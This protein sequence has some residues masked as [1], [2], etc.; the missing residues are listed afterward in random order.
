MPPPTAPLLP[1]IAAVS[2]RCKLLDVAASGENAPPSFEAV[3]CDVLTARRDSARKEAESAKAGLLR[4]ASSSILA[5]LEATD[6]SGEG[7]AGMLRSSDRRMWEA[8]RSAAAAKIA[9]VDRV[10]LTC[11]KQLR[12]SPLNFAKHVE[13]TLDVELPALQVAAARDLAT[14]TRYELVGREYRS[15]QAVL[16]K[17]FAL[18]AVKVLCSSVVIQDK[19]W[20]EAGVPII[21]ASAERPEWAATLS[22]ASS[23]VFSALVGWRG[24]A[25]NLVSASA[26]NDL[27]KMVGMEA[28]G[29]ARLKVTRRFCPLIAPVVRIRMASLESCLTLSSPAFYAPPLR[30]PVR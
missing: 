27:G 11:R 24:A 17:S 7:R 15:I 16:Q 3:A 20:A 21:A 23:G 9:A 13:Q 29:C 8:Q 30:H 10:G 28:L 5:A 18:E 4:L 14:L 22:V 6:E 26:I 19:L 25:L 12:S 1:Q 2:L